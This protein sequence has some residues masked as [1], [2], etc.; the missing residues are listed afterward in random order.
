MEKEKQTREAR[1]AFHSGKRSSNFSNS[2]VA[3]FSL[4]PHSH[5]TYCQQKQ[6][7]LASWTLEIQN[8]L[9]NSISFGAKDGNFLQPWPMNA[10]KEKQR[11]VRKSNTNPM[12]LN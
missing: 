3:L 9:G 11:N 12:N 1:L 10:S 5:P 6:H 8:V 4:I 7:W 2:S